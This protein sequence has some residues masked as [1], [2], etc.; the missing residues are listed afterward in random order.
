[1]KELKSDNYIPGT[2]GWIITADG[3]AEFQSG[4]FRGT[5]KA[6]SGEIGGWEIDSNQIYKLK[7]GAY[8]KI[9]TSPKLRIL[10]NDGSNDRV[11]IGEF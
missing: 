2:Q 3:E 9:Q 8:I 1:M 11:I 10:I 4:V 7:D 5:I 6:S